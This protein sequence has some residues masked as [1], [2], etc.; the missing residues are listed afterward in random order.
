MIAKMPNITVAWEV[1]S[2]FLNPNE[3]LFNIVLCC[4]VFTIGFN[5]ALLLRVYSIK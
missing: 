1:L 3:G 2:L 4:V 5:W